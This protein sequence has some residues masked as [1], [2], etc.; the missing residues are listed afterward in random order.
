MF[1]H[2]V[3]NDRSDQ[4]TTGYSCYAHPRALGAR[5]SAK[6]HRIL[7]Y[8]D[9]TRDQQTRAHSAYC[10]RAIGSAKWACWFWLVAGALADWIGSGVRRRR[11]SA[12]C[13]LVGLECLC[14]GVSGRRVLGRCWGGWCL[15]WGPG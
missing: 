9:A 4:R 7:G 13:A 1:C 10:E 6:D 5:Y 11:C 12:F 3:S 14:L 8:L 2:A 15:A